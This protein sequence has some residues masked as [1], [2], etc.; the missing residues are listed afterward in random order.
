MIK[1]K[2]KFAIIAVVAIFLADACYNP[3]LQIGG[4]REIESGSSHTDS[5]TLIPEG[6]GTFDYPFLVHNEIELGFVGQGAANPE[7]Y[8]NWEMDK[9]YRQVEDINMASVLPFEPI[10]TEAEPFFGRYNGDGHII[11]NLS[12]GDYD[13]MLVG[14]FGFVVGSSA[15]TGI[16]ENLGMVNIEVKGEV[17]AGGIAGYLFGFGGGGI[18]RNCYAIGKFNRGATNDTGPR[19]IGGI[20]GVNDG[21]VENCFAAFKEI[22]GSRSN[23]SVGGIAGN[24]IAAIGGTVRNCV[25]LNMGMVSESSGGRITENSGTLLNNY[26]W[27]GTHL[28]PVAYSLAEGLNN[29]DG[30][31]LSA[32]GIKDEAL[33]TESLNWDFDSED[34]IW[35]WNDGYMPR[36]YNSPAQPWPEYLKM[37]SGTFEDPYLVHNIS[38]LGFVGKGPA[39]S[40]EGYEE[41][42]LDKCYRQVAN[43][44]MAG[45]PF[46]PIGPSTAASFTGIYSG[47][48]HAISN[49]SIGS[50]GTSLAALFGFINGSSGFGIVEN[51][52]MLNVD[53]KGTQFVGAITRLLDNGIIRNCCVTGRLNDGA[54]SPVPSQ[55]GGIAALNNGG[56][57]ENCYTAYEIINEIS[58]TFTGGIVGLNTV[59]GIVQNCVALTN[60]IRRSGNGGRIAFNNPTPPNPGISLN[61][62]SWKF[63][64][65]NGSPEPMLGSH[66]DNDGQPLSATDIKMKTQWTNAANWNTA[67]D[68]KA[69]DFVNTWVWK[70]GYMPSLKNSPALPWP[71]YL[72][73]L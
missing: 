28:P 48:G 70:E 40:I 64:E 45:I 53:I 71:D 22:N 47:G 55:V 6:E 2:A 21:L 63:T 69:W 30:K 25:A 9:F 13:S 62:F 3:F 4:E 15:E 34:W 36:L 11:E 39:N 38:E 67:G 50:S 32:D 8:T 31:P 52:A 66:D 5:I 73:D 41:W 51:L 61:N 42:T 17:K 59:G 35:E 68:A 72:V 60:K 12:I 24:N 7:G 29:K 44:D 37:G 19:S 16:I 1:S 20:V 23:G 10:G 14:L 27:A 49:I 56:L 33:W 43:I 54:I 26:A 65:T 46:S 58:R 57:V 18:V